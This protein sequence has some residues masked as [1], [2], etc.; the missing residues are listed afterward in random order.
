MIPFITPPWLKKFVNLSKGVDKFIAYQRDLMPED[1]RLAVDDMRKAFGVALKARDR[2]ALE[3]LEPKLVRACETAVPGY[4]SSSFRENLEVIIVAV[5]VALG[6]RAYYLQPFKIPTASMQPT[7]NGITAQRIE[8]EAA[9]PNLA[10]KGWEYVWRGRNYVDEVIPAAWGDAEL[11]GFRQRSKANFFTFTDVYFDKGQITVYAPARQLLGEL[12]TSAEVRARC[13]NVRADD[14]P[15]G[16]REDL[17][18]A[19]DPQGRPIRAR[20]RGGEVF[21]RGYVDSG[22]QLLVDKVSY[23]FRRP[24][25]GE[26]F[27]FSTAGITGITPPP[28]TKSQHY[29]KRLVALPGDRLQV[30]PPLLFID[31][32]PAEEEGIAKVAGRGESNTGYPYQ[33]YRMP[34]PPQPPLIGNYVG[35]AE[36]EASSEVVLPSAWGSR[37]YMAMG[38]NS[39][40]SFDSRNWGPVPEENLVGPAFVVYWPFRPH[41]GLIR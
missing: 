31:G 11:I 5:I 1:K 23:H 20:F 7:L 28:G 18:F 34:S 38:D 10:V 14:S 26:V 15:G 19:R 6:I 32:K 33:G 40:N 41:W 25:R 30:R 24:K 4:Q 2:A 35:W 9:M 39:P 17:A 27:V 12:C 21:A 29:I 37:G 13:V 8:D 16:Q 3:D 36:P 22:D